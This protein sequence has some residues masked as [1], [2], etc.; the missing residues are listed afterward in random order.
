MK[1]RLYTKAPKSKSRRSAQT[2]IWKITAG[3]VRMIA[4]ILVFTSEEIWGFLP[5]A[6][7]DPESVHMAEFAEARDLTVN[8]DAQKK[9]SWEEL[10]KVRASVLLKLEEARN[11]K[12]IGGSLEAKVTLTPSL[13][14]L[15]KDRK[16]VV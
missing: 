16:S 6:K 9:E 8:M 1:Y 14:K 12:E 10:A 2:S 15:Q 11:A 3:L 13:P 7:G 5:K 4:P